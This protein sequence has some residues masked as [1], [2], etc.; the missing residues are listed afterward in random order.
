MG[1]L[2]QKKIVLLNYPLVLS[3]LKYRNVWVFWNKKKAGSNR[4]SPLNSSIDNLI[5]KGHDVAIKFVTSSQ[6]RMLLMVQCTKQASKAPVMHEPAHTHTHTD[7]QV[8]L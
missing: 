2:E 1:I 6:T 8:Q 7:T 5:L 4:C 3:L